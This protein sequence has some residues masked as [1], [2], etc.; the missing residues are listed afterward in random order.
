MRF[1]A[2]LASLLFAATVYGQS[3]VTPVF[4]HSM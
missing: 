4:V 1:M 3:I 2:I